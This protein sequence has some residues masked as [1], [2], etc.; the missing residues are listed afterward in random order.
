M[1][2]VAGR[3]GRKNKKGTV[4]IQTGKPDHWIIQKVIAN[5]YIGFYETEIIERKN[6]MYPPFFKLIT[7]SL[8]EKDDKKLVE[9]AAVLGNEL[10]QVFG[11]RILGPEFPIIKRVNNF[12]INVIT[13]KIEREFSPKKV[14]DKINEIIEQFYTQ[15]SFKS[16]RISIDVDPV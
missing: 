10:K 2:Q 3:A 15:V 12:Y 9:G 5:D 4:I 7:I 16:I 11:N 6:F 14:K 13:V 1:S 8:K